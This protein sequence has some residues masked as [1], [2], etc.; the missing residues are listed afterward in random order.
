VRRHFRC[1]ANCKTNPRSHLG[2]RNGYHA[3]ATQAGSCC[4]LCGGGFKLSEPTTGEATI[5]A[6][7]P[8]VALQVSDQA[9]MRR[10]SKS[11]PLGSI[12]PT[13][14]KGALHS[15]PFEGQDFYILDPVPFCR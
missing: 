13:K 1:K 10:T 7:I 8:S 5:G 3:R 11:A 12:N 15:L 14:E 9:A 2:S 6:T 4:V